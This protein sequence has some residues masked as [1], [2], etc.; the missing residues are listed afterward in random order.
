MAVNLGNALVGE[1]KVSYVCCTRMEGLLKQELRPQVGYLF[2]NK[3]HSFDIQAF[4]KLRDFIRENGITIVHAHGTSWFY[5]LLLKLS[6]CKVKL[7]WHD[8]NGYRTQRGNNFLIYASRFFDGVL[9]VNAE[10]E[11]WARK[12]L[13]CKTILR[14]S[15]FVE[16]REA[17]EIKGKGKK[18]QP[19]RMVCVANL[20]EPKNHLNLLEAF[21]IFL[22]QE[23]NAE[24]YLIGKDRHDVYSRNIKKFIEKNKLT[25]KIRIISGE[26]NVNPYLNSANLGVLSSDFEG[27]PV[28]LL[29]YGRAGLPVVCTDVGQCREVAGGSAI[30]IPPGDSKALAAALLDYYWNPVKRK[31]NGQGLRERI[32]SNFS[33]D[34]VLPDLLNFYLKLAPDAGEEEISF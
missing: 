32:R 2:L 16:F 22:Q 11:R 30:L 5:G 12:N 34:A 26:S 9:V 18:G 19:F 3:K 10:L 14:L 24:L 1:V 4:W 23:K 21:E 7:V 25:N 33:K 6:G 15:N 20:R 17:L 8:H 29:E 13:D 28:S 27:L 31:Q